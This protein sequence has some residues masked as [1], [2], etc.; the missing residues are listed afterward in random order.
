M[1]CRASGTD[2]AMIHDH[3]I[4][5]PLR[6]ISARAELRVPMGRIARAVAFLSSTESYYMAGLSISGS[7]GSEMS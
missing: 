6:G 2:A 5:L 1:G 3:G 7:G 4:P